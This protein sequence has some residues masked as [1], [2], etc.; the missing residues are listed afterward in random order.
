MG[1]NIVFNLPDHTYVNEALGFTS[2]VQD[3]F[4]TETARQA[5]VVLPALSWAE[6]DGSCTNLEGRMQHLKKVV[7][8]QGLEDWKTLSEV[9]ALLGAEM[10]YKNATHVLARF[11]KC[12][13]CTK[14]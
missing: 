5:D 1:E 3:I 7:D 8:G 6:K 9:G 4:L 13:L 12:P 11:Q 2:V 10:H 14:A